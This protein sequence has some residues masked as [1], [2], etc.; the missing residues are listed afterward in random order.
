MVTSLRG[1][2]PEKEAQAPK[3][4]YEAEVKAAMRRD[5]EPSS[6]FAGYFIWLVISL[7][8]WGVAIWWF[9]FR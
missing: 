8:F 4:E 7:P 1:P 6:F 2:L 3:P 5:E 9:F